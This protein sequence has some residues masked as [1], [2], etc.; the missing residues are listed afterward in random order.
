M[1]IRWFHSF[2]L[3]ATFLMMAVGVSCVEPFD[4]TP[5]EVSE[6]C[7]LTFQISIASPRVMTKSVVDGFADE[8]KIYDLQVWAYTHGGGKEEYAIA[9]AHL[10][11]EAGGEVSPEKLTMKFRSNMVNSDATSLDFY[12]LANGSSVGF[13]QGE[14][15]Q[16][17]VLQEAVFGDGDGSGF[18]TACVDGVPDGSKEGKGKGLPMSG[19]FGTGF[20]ISFLRFGFTKAQIDAIKEKA[21]GD[22]KEN[23]YDLSDLAPVTFSPVQEDF[24]Q[25]TLCRPVG[26]VYPSWSTLFDQIS[27]KLYLNRA[28]TRIRFVFAKAENMAAITQI[29][30]IQIVDEN[31]LPVST[32]LFPRENTSDT[33]IKRDGTGYVD[34]FIWTGDNGILLS[35]DNILSVDTP[36]RFR[37]TDDQI[38]Q[39]YD[40]LLTEI[41]N[42]KPSTQKLLYLRESDKENCQCVISYKIDNSDNSTTIT[43]PGVRLSR[44]TGWTIYAYFMSYKLEFQV[45]VSDNWDNLQVVNVPG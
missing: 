14:R 13:N 32:Y 8:A 38:S 4:N 12:V 44:N 27:P 40:Y 42:K 11:D 3:L 45:S 2:F 29:T 30:S 20:D 39:D 9:Y 10:F 5:P 7:E 19:Y 37:K 21:T 18:G 36:L 16:R 33:D 22:D 17:K 24:I 43:F 15:P 6:D 26:D 35:N 23:P 28:I 34:P 31:M 41:V 25:N 1:S